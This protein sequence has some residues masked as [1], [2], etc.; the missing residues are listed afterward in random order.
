MADKI[1]HKIFR[2]SW[3][4]YGRQDLSE[5]SSLFPGM[6]D[7]IYHQRI[8]R[9]KETGILHKKYRFCP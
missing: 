4:W 3:N 6:A 5:D 9:S 1:F 8:L 7:K 2:F